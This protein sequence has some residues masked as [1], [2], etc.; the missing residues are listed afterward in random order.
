MNVVL[1]NFRLP[2]SPGS[3]HILLFEWLDAISD[4]WS[5]LVSANEDTKPIVSRK[6][7]QPKPK[8][9][10]SHEG[11]YAH[12]TCMRNQF[13]V[14]EQ[15]ETNKCWESPA[16]FHHLPCTHQ[17]LALPTYAAPS[18]IEVYCRCLL[19]LRVAMRHVK[20]SHEIFVFEQARLV[21][22][23]HFSRDG[24]LRIESDTYLSSWPTEQLLQVLTVST[25][26]LSFCIS[27]LRKHI[28]WMKA[29]WWHSY[30]FHM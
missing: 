26:S 27:A 14:A 24:L 30:R 10:L 5:D 7:Q 20:S 28:V 17:R 29:L 1:A 22:D 13:C 16:D 3:Q 19:S 11:K 15:F 9:H 4:S 12:G 23:T 21:A 18:L 25:L 6:P 8:P 2:N